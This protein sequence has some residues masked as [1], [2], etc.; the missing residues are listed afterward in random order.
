[1]DLLCV[2]DG[3]REEHEILAGHK[4]EYLA[5]ALGS[6]RQPAQYPSS[7][8]YQV[9]QYIIEERG[10]ELGLYREG[11]SHTVHERKK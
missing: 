3:I 5:T 1:M 11:L 4:V 10:V 7:R 2:W 8:F 6:L 9:D